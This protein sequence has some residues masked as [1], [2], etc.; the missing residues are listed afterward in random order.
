VF[1]IRRVGIPL[2]CGIHGNFVAMIAK[3]AEGEVAGAAEQPSAGVGHMIPV[4]VELEE[5]VLDEVFCGFAL[6]YEALGVTEQRRFLC[7][8]DL[9]ECG[10]GLHFRGSRR[11]GR[12]G[13]LAR[14]NHLEGVGEVGFHMRVTGN[15]CFACKDDTPVWNS[16]ENNLKRWSSVRVGL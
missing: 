9:A 7:F 8:E 14:F 16:L 2:V 6:P 11:G 5:G 3:V 1:R 15:L 10:F 4:G 13:I 12:Q